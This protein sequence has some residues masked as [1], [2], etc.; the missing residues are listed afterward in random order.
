MPKTITNSI[1]EKLSEIGKQL[2]FSVEKEVDFKMFPNSYNPRYDVVW[3]WNVDLHIP[4]STL[5]KYI[6]KAWQ[7]HLSKIPIA[8]FETE[9]STTTSKNQI[10]NI[11]NLAMSPAFF[12][13]LVTN[14]DG[15]SD[16]NDIYR[17]AIKIA[18]TYDS[19]FSNKQLIVLDN[20]HL[21]KLAN[22][23]KVVIKKLS[24]PINQI[25]RNGSGGE[26]KSKP[27]ADKIIKDFMESHLIQMNDFNPQEYEWKYKNINKLQKI[28]THPEY[29][30]IL[31]KMCKWIPNDNEGH[32]IKKAKDYYYVPKLDLVYG[33]NLPA[34]FVAWLKELSIVLSPEHVH[35]PIL[36]YLSGS[37][38]YEIFLPLLGVEIETSE[39]KHSNAAAINLLKHCVFGI[40]I[41]NSAFAS[42]YNT[43]KQAFGLLNVT[44]KEIEKL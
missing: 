31:G 1:N 2:G 29:D 25:E 26:K 32:P 15:A 38:N 24:K 19:F 10:G 21:E 9:G 35:F 16:E 4:E 14:N 33:L 28:D 40:I 17:R 3:F 8:T 6:P 42:H 7:K 23:V 22:N 27:I 12:N 11:A 34:Q 30:Y 39:N 37:D 36:N 13:F 43:L 44:F 5:N 41:S 18:R 20:F